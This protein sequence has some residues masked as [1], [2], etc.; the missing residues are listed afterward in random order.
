MVVNLLFLALDLKK[1]F[2]RYILYGGLLVN[3]LETT[4]LFQVRNGTPP[5]TGQLGELLPF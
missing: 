5:P 4:T 3:C 1:V 2:S